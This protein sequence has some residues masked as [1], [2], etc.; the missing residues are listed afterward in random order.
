MW[1]TTPDYGK[2]RESRL[3]YRRD[4]LI[5]LI[6]QLARVLI[7]A[8]ER[9]LGRNLT[10]EALLRE[11]EDIAGQAGLDLRLARELDPQM[12]LM[13]LAP[14]GEIDQPK[15]WLL[16]EL[17]YLEGIEARTTGEVAAGRADLARSRAIFA[18][19]PADWQPADELPSAGERRA[20]IDRLLEGSSVG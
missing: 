1:T 18:H 10:R 4:Y 15:F 11:T 20:E 9:I 14:T 8:R 16:A 3:M 12:L 17:L 6:E 19:L 5:R 2:N 7:T 13:W